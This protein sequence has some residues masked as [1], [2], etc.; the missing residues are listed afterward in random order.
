MRP[1]RAPPFCPNYIS[2]LPT[3]SVAPAQ[4]RRPFV[5]YPILLLQLALL[6]ASPAFLTLT[7]F[8]GLRLA[9]ELRT[10]KSRAEKFEQPLE[11][12]GE[13]YEPHTV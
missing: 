12:F 1:P 3:S 10:F 11:A 7:F 13:G 2:T 9:H 5:S 6:P 8:F 4:Q